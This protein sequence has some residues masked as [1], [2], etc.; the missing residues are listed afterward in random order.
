MDEASLRR[1][2]T[3]ILQRTD[4]ARDLP[5]GSWWVGD[6]AGAARVRDD[7]AAGRLA[8]RRAHLSA[9]SGLAALGQDNLEMAEH[10][11]TNALWLYI[12]ALEKRMRPEAKRTLGR[13][14]GKRGRPKKT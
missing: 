7:D 1:Q 11:L 14:A 5:P 10:H 13:P 8:W 2:L 3:A 12:D 4:S 6:K 9:K